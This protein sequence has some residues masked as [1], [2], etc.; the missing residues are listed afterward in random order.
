VTLSVALRRPGVTRHHVLRS[1]DFPRTKPRGL[2][3]GPL[4]LRRSRSWLI[5][6]NN[7]TRCESL[8][9]IRHAVETVKPTW[10]RFVRVATEWN[11]RVVSGSAGIMAAWA[12]RAG[13][14][15]H[16]ETG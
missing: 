1:P 11:A 2:I 6:F 7:N 12:M 3:R 4:S 9:L 13:T 14:T 8:P 10:M 16:W 5:D 15:T